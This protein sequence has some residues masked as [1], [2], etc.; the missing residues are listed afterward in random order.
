MLLDAC[1]F[2]QF[3]V[4]PR[5]SVR[6][7][8][9]ARPGRRE[10]DWIVRVLFMLLHQ[11][12]H[13]LLRQRHLADRVFRFRFCHIQLTLHAGD[14]LIH[15]QDALFHIQ[16]C[17]LERQ[18]LTPAQA[19]GQFQIEHG[20]DAVLLRLL[21]VSAYLLRRQDGHLLLVLGRDTA[22]LA[23]VV[24]DEPLFHRLLQR[25]LQH[26][27]DA[28]HKGVGQG[29]TVLLRHALHPAVFLGLVVHPLDV[30]G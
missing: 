11:Q 4:D 12:V 25:R 29:F 19:A 7:P 2:Q 21:K 14:L 28:P 15:R 9:S 6:A 8:V 20:Q 13:C 27:V 30:D 17:P 16:I 1:V 22:V 10:Q 3:P 5:H 26:R 18:Q 23:G 24:R